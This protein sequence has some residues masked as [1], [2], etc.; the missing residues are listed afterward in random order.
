MENLDKLKITMLGTVVMAIIF[1]MAMLD[2]T[3]HEFVQT[4]SING[5]IAAWNRS[6]C[7]QNNSNL[8]KRYDKHF[9]TSNLVIHTSQ[10][11]VPEKMATGTITHSS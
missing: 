2:Y 3:A 5:S 10:S 7:P 8:G 11:T 1:L 4:P 9:L 6:L